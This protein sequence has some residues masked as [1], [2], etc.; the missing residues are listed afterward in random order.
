MVEVSDHGYTSAL[1]PIKLT[2]ITSSDGI[3]TSYAHAKKLL[4]ASFIK[5]KILPAL[6]IINLPFANPGLKGFVSFL[7]KRSWT[8]TIPVIYSEGAL[9]DGE[10]IE[11][12]ACNW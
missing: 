1:L 9:S 3:A 5:R 10:L 6:I 11:L 7:K 2:P 8:K 4:R 12:A